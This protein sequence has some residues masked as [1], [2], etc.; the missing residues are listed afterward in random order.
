MEQVHYPIHHSTK[1]ERRKRVTKQV[2]KGLI[3]Y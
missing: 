1:L 3:K 2:G